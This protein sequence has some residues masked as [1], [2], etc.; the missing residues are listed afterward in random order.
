MLPVTPAK[1]VA[2]IIATKRMQHRSRDTCFIA[3]PP[4]TDRLSPVK[5]VA[6]EVS[7][8][9]LRPFISVIELNVAELAFEYTI[10]LDSVKKY[11]QDF[12]R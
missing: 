4:K 10:Y 2:A 11:L 6:S 12:W 7:M 5:S 3:R 1:A 8:H 9:P